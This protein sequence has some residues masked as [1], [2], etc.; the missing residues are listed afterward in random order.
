M[1]DQYEDRSERWQQRPN[2]STTRALVAQAPSV[3]ALCLLA[4]SRRHAACDNT[5]E[6][7]TSTTGLLR[8]SLHWIALP[9]RTRWCD[10]LLSGDGSPSSTSYA[11]AQNCDIVRH[12]DRWRLDIPR[13]RLPLNGCE[14]G[15]SSIR[16]RRAWRLSVTAECVASL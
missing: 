9:S 14:A 4:R 5:L 10:R 11:N 1:F 12:T 6:S 2:W 13:S 15:G 16:Q 7:L 8:E 3:V